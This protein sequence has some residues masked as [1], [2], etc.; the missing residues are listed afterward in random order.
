MMSVDSELL[1]RAG[2]CVHKTQTMVLS[3]AELELRDT[4]I[5]CAFAGCLGAV[6]RTLPV[7]QVTRGKRLLQAS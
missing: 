3:W 7:D 6:V 2:A 1:E 4:S 5:G